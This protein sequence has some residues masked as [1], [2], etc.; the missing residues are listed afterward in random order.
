[1]FS[2][3][4]LC[5]IKNPLMIEIRIIW[6]NELTESFSSDVWIMSAF[7]DTEPIYSTDENRSIL[8][9]ETFNEG[10][11]YRTVPFKQFVQFVHIYI[12][13]FICIFASQC[14]GVLCIYC[15]TALR[16][17]PRDLIDVKS[18]LFKLRLWRLSEC[19]PRSL[20]PYNVTKPQLVN[21]IDFPWW[22]LMTH[23]VCYFV[24][25][26]GFLT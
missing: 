13:K 19:W 11:M 3:T 8:Y 1:M 5:T 26:E 9:I 21:L 18:T 15:D 16:L 2:E 6:K 23:T 4:K 20:S 24:S 12:Y 17:M 7:I 22:H 25:C 10:T 14:I